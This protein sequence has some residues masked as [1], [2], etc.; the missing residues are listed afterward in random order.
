MSLAQHRRTVDLALRAGNDLKALFDK[1]GHADAPRGRLLR[2]YRNARRAMSGRMAN[3]SAVDES[4]QEL[5]R[6][7]MSGMAELFNQ[8]QLLGM[9]QAE[10]QLAVYDTLPVAPSPTLIQQ[11]QAAGDAWLATLDAQLAKARSLALTGSDEAL[12]LGDDDRAGVLTPGPVLTEGARWMGE[13]A[14]GSFTLIV[15][16]SAKASGAEFWKQA[17]A[18]L[19][20]RTTDCCLRVSGQAVPLDS[21][22]KLTGEPRYAD[23][24]SD[25]PFHF[26]CRTAEALVLAS[27]VDDALSREM[28]TSARE[29][30]K[31]RDG[32]RKRPGGA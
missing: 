19:D 2:A 26:W 30:L 12:V 20:K 17:I 16:E 9:T 11:V 4:L 6:S 27:D 3:P 8:A 22:F 29:M 32:Q 1:M 31:S 13:L 7:A 15:N 25:P 5:R 21:Q 23:E 28:R 10:R 18:A 14:L 24:V